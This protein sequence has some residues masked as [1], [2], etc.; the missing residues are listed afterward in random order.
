L[1]KKYINIIDYGVGNIFSI[2]KSI[3]SLGYSCNFV[4]KP[5]DLLKNVK[6][7]LPGVGSFPECKKLLKKKKLDKIIINETSKGTSLLGVCVGMQLLMDYSLELKKTKGLGLI[8]GKVEK[9]K[10]DKINKVPNTGWRQVNFNNKDLDN[11][12][13]YFYFVHSYKVKL[14]NKKNQTGFIKYGRNIIPAS[15]KKNNIY[16]CQFH[17]EK[18]GID[19][20]QFLKSFLDE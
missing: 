18:S 10:S 1:K 14:K 19:G 9:I 15:I 3:E 20:I 12:K 5:S 13:N 11:K 8:N 4:K 2:S 17:P 6:I 7:I 16:G